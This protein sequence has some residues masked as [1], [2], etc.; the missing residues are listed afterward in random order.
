MKAKDVMTKNVV[1]FSSEMTLYDAAKTLI[2]KRISGAPVADSGGKVIGVIT[3]KDLI[4]SADFVG[5]DRMK[6]MAVTEIMSTETVSF[7][8]ES[9]ISEIA[10]ALIHKN[11][12]R[13]PIVE[14]GTCLGIVS[15]SDVLKY[16][17]GRSES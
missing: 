14:N 11:I 4:V 3:E 2:E 6:T 7:T 13:V 12:K 9:D 8:S 16:L 10:T 17:V 1:V 5:S 15:R